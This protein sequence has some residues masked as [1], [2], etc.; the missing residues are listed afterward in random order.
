VAHSEL[1]VLRDAAAKA[2]AIIQA[3]TKALPPF[4]GKYFPL[5]LHEV[6]IPE[7]C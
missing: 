3:M 5:K 4:K 7:S 6:F 1:P 2:S